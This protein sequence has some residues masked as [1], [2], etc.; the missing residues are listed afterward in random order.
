[1]IYNHNNLS[2]LN[3][4]I[5][6]GAGRSAPYQTSFVKSDIKGKPEP[7]TFYKEFGFSRFG[8]P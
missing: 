5:Q 8:G 3:D 4:N 6:K 7:F 1:M 2:V